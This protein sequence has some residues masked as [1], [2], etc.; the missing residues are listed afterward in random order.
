M[1][2]GEAVGRKLYKSLC[3]EFERSPEKDVVR[4]LSSPLLLRVR[5]HRRPE[6]CLLPRKPVVKL[7]RKAPPLQEKRK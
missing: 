2:P 5:E 3:E 1:E 6:R 4:A 7:T